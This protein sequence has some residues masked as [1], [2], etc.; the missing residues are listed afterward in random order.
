MKKSLILCLV[1]VV[2]SA[3]VSA[4]FFFPG[5]PGMMGMNIDTNAIKN[6]NNNVNGGTN[7]APPML[8][9]M[10][11]M[12]PE[13][14]IDSTDI[15]SE[16]ELRRMNL[17]SQRI[18]LERE[19]SYLK[20]KDPSTLTPEEKD[21][22]KV[23]T[24]NLK[25]V[26]MQEKQILEEQQRELDKLKSKKNLPSSSIY[27]H[28]FFR[29]GSFK[30]FQK[31]DES[32][33]GE[34]YVLGTGDV[35]QIEVWGFRYW[36]KTYVVNESGSIDIDGY[37]KLFVKGMPLKKVREMVG[38]RL[39]ISSGESSYSVAVTRSRMV[40][41]NV[42]GEVFTPGTYSLPATNSAFNLLVSMG[43]P[44]DIGSV[45]NIYIKREGKVVD[46]F[47]LYEYYSDVKH[48]RD[49]YLQNND[50]VIVAP[51]ANVINVQGAVR[52]PGRYELKNKENL[53]DLI[54]F[55]GGV[56]HNVYLKDVVVS[57]IKDNNWEVLSVN[58]DSLLKIKK[59]FELTGGETVEFKFINVD[60]Q[61]MAR[62]QGAVSVPG[63]YRV[64]KGIRLSAMIKTANGL[65]SDAFTK[66]GYIVRTSNQFKKSYLTFSP[67]D[68]I[69]SP[70]TTVDPEIEDRDTVVI[71]RIAD[72]RKFRKVKISGAVRKPFEKQYI[73]GMK[74]GEM[75]F[76]A[77]GL[78][79]E[80]DER[81]G[82]IL[83][84]DA[85]Y[86]KRTIPFLPGEVLAGSSWFD[87]EV[88]PMDEVMIYS[89]TEF[90]RLYNMSITG[91]VK[92]PGKFEFSEG[93]RI[94]DLINMAGGVESYVFKSRGMVIHSD[95][96]TGYQSIETINLGKIM[97]NPDDPENIELRKNDVVQLFDMTEMKNDFFV[98]IYGPVRNEGLYN[99]GNN[100]TLQNLVDAAGGLQ[101]ITAGTKVEVVRNFFFT[102]GKYQFLK[103]QVFTTDISTSLSLDSQLTS[104]KLQPF[105]KVFVRKNPNFMPLKLVYIDGA[106][107]YPGFYALQSETEK[108]GSIIKRAGGYK[109]NANVNGS[110]LRR[111]LSP[112]DT[113][114]VILKTPKAMS[115]RSN[116]FNHIMKGGDYITIPYS[117]NLVYLTGE[118]NKPTPH[119]L[120]AYYLRNKR[121][122]FY[123]NFFGGGF[124]ATSDKKHL[125]VVYQNGKSV[126]TRTIF[127]V[128]KYPK[129]K[130]GCT[131]VVT[132]KT[133]TGDKAVSTGRRFSI[134]NFMNQTMMRATTVL[135]LM[136]IY[137]LAVGR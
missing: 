130:P 99:Y 61:F 113:I 62:I 88:L 131:I 2:F 125:K 51:L 19:L 18:K 28:Q 128:R 102:N 50:Y 129:V 52:R 71:Y 21:V 65:T 94:T 75:L 135:S 133:K 91:P 82:F 95:L 101:F 111:A 107:N 4:Q 6:S 17:M 87:F 70:G 119:D 9:P 37:Q 15:K 1:A 38:A 46:S 80:A 7:Q 103:P 89:K 53:S 93:T 36:S 31:T 14:P 132:N 20:Q 134:D 84:T 45:R 127:F 55:A 73:E 67:E 25:M 59:N 8:T 66:R 137:R 117:D 56:Y 26:A 124:T 81:N 33:V 64:K 121:A 118:I 100:M 92:A 54:R 116:R 85:N 32:A 72:L 115:D 35:V 10:P 136:G 110:R 69:K 47:D 108:L 44:S 29:D 105:D 120:G 68:A 77:G 42:F 83:R 63:N 23:Q 104:L 11:K 123:V 43:G 48:Q 5:M 97:A 96:E 122:K 22:M 112:G 76:M 40:S 39:G 79:E 78:T 57:R 16:L 58:L 106:I 60:N 74:L 90:R 114:E 24:E 3:R 13:K 30:F 12:D 27:G 109:P 98:S 49:V 126:G 34:N 41:V 86:N